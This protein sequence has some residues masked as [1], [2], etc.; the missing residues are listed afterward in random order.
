[1]GLFDMFGAGGGSLTIQPST[2]HVAAG[3]MIVGNVVFQ[4][5]TRSQQINALTIRLTQDARSMQMTNQGPQPRSESR[6]VVPAT[7]LTQPV[8]TTPGQPMSFP[9]QLQLPT[10]L[11]GS[12]PQQM[13]Y[14]LRA[15]ADIPGEVD[16]GASIEIHV[17]GDAQPG[18]MQP[19][20]MQPDAQPGVPSVAGVV[21]AAAAALGVAGMMQP[22]MMQPGMMQPGMMQPGM[23]PM[24][25]APMQIA[26]DTRVY[27]QWQG[28]GQLHPATVRGFANGYYQVDWQDPRLGANSYV[29]PQQ[30][31][32]PTP[33]GPG[34]MTP[35][36]PVGHGAPAPQGYAKQPDPY[37]KQ[38]DPYA[39]QP[40]PYA[41]QG[42]PAQPG[43]AKQPDPYAKQGAPA[44]PGFAKQPDP[45]A[46]QGAPAQPFGKGPAGKK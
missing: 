26:P 4:G 31:Q 46:K 11:P 42:A 34:A 22:D 18:M 5:G 13:S 38:P 27:A 10:S 25:G 44:Q 7:P 45:Y 40:D 20:M 29:L 23:P 12:V 8:Q 30:I 35:S 21:G 19:G 39:K 16:P 24:G 3:Q 6:D 37:A 43:F 14:H 2:P 17:V 33:S 9:F 28:D 32:L 41:K 1:M 15:T 36:A